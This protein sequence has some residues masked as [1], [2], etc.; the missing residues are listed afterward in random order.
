MAREVVPCC[1]GS[2]NGVYAVA[3]PDAEPPGQ[4]S[5]GEVVIHRFASAQPFAAPT[6]HRDHMRL[7]PLLLLFLLLIPVRTAGADPPPPTPAPVGSFSWPLAPPHPVLRPFQPPAA[8]WGPGHRGVDLGG[9][10]GDAVLAVADGTVVFAG[11]LVDRPVISVDHADGLRSTYEP[12]DP[13]VSTGQAVHRGDLLGHLLPGHTECTGA[14][15]C[16][17]WGIKR[18]NEY[19]DPL[20]LVSATRHVR[21]LPWPGGE[22]ARG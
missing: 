20:V 13:A 17:H 6:R 18:G 15:A 1:H 5:T 11:Q 7:T 10:A 19:L 3:T 16:L 12:V 2:R 9:Q 4:L 8:P 21:L 22:R 14:P